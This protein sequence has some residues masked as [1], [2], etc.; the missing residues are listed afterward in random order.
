MYTLIELFNLFCAGI[1]AGIEV[2]VHYA[3]QPSILKM[4]ERQQVY[5]R[6]GL[7][8]KLRWMV[9]AFFVP[10][11]L[12]G[13]AITIIPGTQPALYFHL[14]SILAIIVWI[15]IR[16][17]GTVP[18]NSATIEWNPDSPPKDWKEQI[19]KVERFHILG[20]WAA[21]LAFIFFLAAFAVSM[22]SHF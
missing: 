16:I 14:A 9:P 10:M 4:E 17:V 19:A 22:Q 15:L 21:I 7:I 13:I 11:A 2:A 18:V 3:F 1:L 12:S 5:L 20:T 8:R 6:Q